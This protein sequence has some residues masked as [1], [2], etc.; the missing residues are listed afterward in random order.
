MH[1]LALAKGIIDIVLSEQKRQGFE[2]VL[3]I[4]LRIGEFSGVVPECI[5]EFFPIAAADSPA[6][7]ARLTVESIP[8]SFLC[9]DCGHEGAADRKNVCCMNCGSTALKMTA[10]REFYVESINVE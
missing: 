6:K 7:D 9:L 2:R 1:E 10:G 3:E 8:A 4:K 5:R